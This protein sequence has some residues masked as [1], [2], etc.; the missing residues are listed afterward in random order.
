MHVYYIC[1]IGTYYTH[2]TLIIMHVLYVNT[3]VTCVACVTCIITFITCEAC[4]LGHVRNVVRAH[5]QVTG[6]CDREPNSNIS[7]I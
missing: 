5:K 1:Q 7:T 4:L 6:M 2:G 3:Y